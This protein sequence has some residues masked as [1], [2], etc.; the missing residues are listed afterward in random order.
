MDGRYACLWLDMDSTIRRFLAESDVGRSLLVDIA[1]QASDMVLANKA[2]ISDA[3]TSL[4]AHT[5]KPIHSSTKEA[6]LYS[7]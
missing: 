6:A 3:V 2:G 1:T 4:L 7:I 5:F